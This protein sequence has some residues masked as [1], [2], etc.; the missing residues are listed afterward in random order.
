MLDVILCFDLSSSMDDFTDVW[1]VS[2]FNSGGNNGYTSKNK[3]GSG[4]NS[5][6]S[7]PMYLA[8]GCS[9]T[10]GTGT[11][12]TWPLLMG[13]DG[14]VSIS[15]SYHGSN[16][17]VKPSSYSSSLNSASTVTDITVDVSSTECSAKGAPTTSSN[18]KSFGTVATSNVGF[19]V[20]AS[21]GNLETSAAATSAGVTAAM[22]SSWGSTS[23]I[24]TIVPGTGWFAA[25]WELANDPHLCVPIGAGL[26]ASQN[27]F[28]IMNN[29]TDAHFGLVTYADNEGSSATSTTGSGVNA[30]GGSNC[31]T[32]PAD[33]VYASG[34]PLPLIPLTPGATAAATNYTTCLQIMQNK[35][36]ASNASQSTMENNQ[37]KANGSTDIGG[38]LFHAMDLI[39]LSTDHNADGYSPSNKARIGAT[40]AIVLFTDGLPT[41]Q[42][43]SIAPAQIATD[44]KGIGVPIYCIGLCMTPTLQ[45]SQNAALNTIVNNSGNGAQYFQATSVQSLDNAFEAVAR[46]LVQL[47]R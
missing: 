39:M 40:R 4:V 19:L 15:S 32:L 47:V 8:M 26:L 16:Q 10:T 37:L 44:A 7:Q 23:G 22:L 24:G 5:N 34:T 46:S 17:H 28:T 2:R 1:L 6:G 21:R 13:T 20:E 31:T 42:T 45:A 11:N 35:F 14:T 27:F 25:Y 43:S 38:A 12:N 29:D 3:G 41:V 9:N 18:G 36:N 30:Y 33:D